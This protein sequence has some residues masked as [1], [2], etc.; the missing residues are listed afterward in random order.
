MTLSKKNL[1]VLAAA[2][3]VVLGI[4]AYLTWLRPAPEENVSITGMGST[5]EA[6]AAFLT[7]AAQLEPVGF[8]A[9]VLSDPRFLS[10]VDMKTAIVPEP[11]GR[12]DP[13]APLSGVASPQ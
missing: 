7:L 8:D 11:E 6:Q 2:G 5:S 4:V 1:Q 10:L 3:I 13:F 12:I 9:S